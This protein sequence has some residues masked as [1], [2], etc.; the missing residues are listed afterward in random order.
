MWLIISY[1]VAAIISFVFFL[2]WTIEDIKFA[3]AVFSKR[4]FTVPVCKLIVFAIFW[5][6][7]WLHVIINLFV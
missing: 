4:L 3:N 6:I 2:K 7:T 5:P 1:V